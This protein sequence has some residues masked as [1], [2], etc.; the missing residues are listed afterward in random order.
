MEERRKN[1]EELGKDLKRIY[2]DADGKLPDF[3]RLDGK[4]SSRFRSMLVG[5]LV[6]GLVM[7][8]AVWA[9]VFFFSRTSGFNGNKVELTIG[10]SDGLTGG[11]ETDVTVHYKNGERVP[12]AQGS[13]ELK[14]P[15]GFQIISSDPAA[16]P[17]GNWQIGAI[18]AGAEGQI[19]VHGMVRRELNAAL[20]FEATLNYKPADF[21]SDFQKV[22]SHTVVVKDAVLTLKGSGPDQLTPGDDIAFVFDYEN[23]SDTALENVR[24][25]ADAPDGFIPSTSDPA[26]DSDVALRWTF[27]K[28]EAHAKGSVTVNGTFSATSRGPKSLMGHMGFTDDQDNL[29]VLAEAEAKTE[30]L[31][32]N[33]DLS[34]IVNGSNTPTPATFGDTLFFA[35]RYENAGDV[36]LKEVTISAKLPSEPAGPSI[37]DW[38]AGKDDLKG[39]HTDSQL[40][41]TKK[42]LP[43]L[44]SLSPGDKG[45]IDFSIPLVGKPFTDAKTTDYVVHA[46]ASA[47]IGKAGTAS[48]S[49]E[50]DTAPFDV[51]LL[52]DTSFSASGRY[53]TDDGTPLGSGPMPPQASQKTVYRIFWT[54]S[55]GL[56]ELT[57]LTASTVLPQGVKWTG[58]QRQVDAGALTFDDTGRQA[59]WRLNRMPTSVKSVVV[60]FDVELTPGSEDIGKILDLTGD[61]RLEAFDKDVSAV[62]LKTSPPVG[63][64]LI[65]DD[66]ATGKG[67]VKE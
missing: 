60:S 22:A 50:V 17:D 38:V 14:P 25:V 45:E 30:V 64:D 32:S 28:I 63:T 29:I 26:A 44:A 49:R 43:A 36:T 8:A 52:S 6:T 34:L 39:K 46:V 42:E 59:T 27:P 31:K 66:T 16:G 2:S 12:L 62:I 3:T 20:T 47:L 51:H 41:W 48:G 33:L 53:Y 19:K 23:T 57:N 61:N 54:I 7:A 13:L 67:V 4:P 56:H 40:V 55:N 35:I 10:S 24:L 37:L 1:A 65:G 21:N 11:A 15:P 58:V 18:A 5:A 9:G